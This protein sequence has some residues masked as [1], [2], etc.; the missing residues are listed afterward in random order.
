[1]LVQPQDL[2]KI[3]EKASSLSERL[4]PDFCPASSPEN[5]QI[6]EERLE[7]WCQVVTEGDWQKF[8]QHLN[9]IGLN[10]ES[11]RPVVSTV[12][13]QGDRIPHW[14][15]TLHQVLQSTAPDCLEPSHLKRGERFLSPLQP[16][17]FEEIWIAAI[18]VARQ[19]LMAQ[20]GNHYALLTPTAHATLERSLLESLTHLGSRPLFQRFK[21]FRQQK[22]PA[23]GRILELTP[24]RSKEQYQPF[25]THFLNGELLE[26]FQEYPVL[27]RLVGITI[28]FWVN[29]HTEF[30]QRLAADWQEI[31]ETFQ[32]ELA[33]GLVAALQPDLSDRHHQGRTAI[34]LEFASGLKLVYKPKNLGTEQAYSHLLAWLN[35]RQPPLSLKELKVLNRSV[36]GWVEFVEHLPCKTPLE[37]CQ[38]YQRMGMFLCLA[39]VLKGTDFLDDN[40]IACGAY[41]VPVDLEMLLNHQVPQEMKVNHDDAYT[42]AYSQMYSS[43]LDTGL[44][45][46]WLFVATG[47]SIDTSGVGGG[48][49]QETLFKVSKWQNINTDEMSLRVEYDVMPPR[50]NIPYL[51]GVALSPGDYLEDLVT[52]FGQMYQFLQEHQTELLADNSPFH[53]LAQ[54]QVRFVFRATK[55]YAVLLETSLKV[56]AL[57]DGINRSIQL[58]FL[59]RERFWNDK[60]YGLRS[61]S[62]SDFWRLIQAEQQALEQLDIPL[63]TAYPNQEDVAIAPHT[64]LEHCFTEPS[65]NLALSRLRQLSI[66]DLERQIG[67]IRGSLYAHIAARGERPSLIQNLE[68]QLDLVP[69]LNSTELVQQ[70]EAIATHLQNSA[71][72]APN[73][74]IGWIG[75][76]FVLEIQRF[77]LEPLNDSL[78]DGNCG[79]ALFFAA[80]AKIQPNPVYRQSALSAV[81]SLRQSLQQPSSRQA[82]LAKIGI[83]GAVGCG[84]LIYSLTRIGEFLEETNCIEDAAKLAAE[85]TPEQF[86]GDR[87]LDIISGTAGAIL[88]LLALYQAT[89]KPQILEQAILGGRHL[90]A[91][92]SL[93]ASHFRAWQTVDHQ[94]LT[95]FSHGA[96][97]IAYSLLRLYH[98]CGEPEFLA[99]AQEA[100]ASENSLFA[101]TVGNWPDLRNSARRSGEPQFTATWCHGAPGIGLARLGGLNSLNT[102][103]IL[104]D[105]ETALNTTQKRSWQGL[106]QLCCGNFGLIDFLLEAGT[107]LDRPELMAIAQK[108]AAWGV[109]RAQKTGFFQT[110]DRMTGDRYSPGFFTGTAGIGYELLR[111]AYP[112]LLPSVLLWA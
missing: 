45:P 61:H 90:L 84:S 44:L 51:D 27:G 31:Q 26:F 56:E 107:R 100:I 52:G 2:I 93:S 103:E 16:L 108:Q 7:R 39:Y 74:S 42:L 29:S 35:D 101:P 14:A 37:A 65:I 30:I 98:V 53:L 92:R 95:G 25:I 23:L 83:G 60:L 21:V 33:L 10:L 3:V 59:S 86:A 4:S 28:N 78:Y 48:N 54:Q 41:P 70:A 87:Q 34:A 102:A 79:I 13:F 96:A 85:L 57:K 9:R 94:F 104:Q 47:Q 106:D 80:L 111:L 91:T 11:A 112:H 46:R 55:I 63:L 8:Q 49:S 99:A 1:M 105:I 22:Q 68:F 89:Q 97:G 67:F 75:L 18:S 40:I 64:T 38:Y 77:Q 62:E 6:I 15:E 50:K 36:Y 24:T 76:S 43:V 82:M 20:V 109:T 110:I 81:Q 72:Q 32:P 5:S 71:I 58:D 12:C 73:H 69:L 17:P 88:G 19:Q 66:E